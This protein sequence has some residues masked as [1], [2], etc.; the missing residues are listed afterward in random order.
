MG[1]LKANSFDEIWRSPRAEQVRELVKECGRNCWMTGSSV[2]AMR[3]NILKPL[4]WVIGN[5][6]RLTFGRSINEKI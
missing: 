6:F 2:P 3:R 5:K 1:D 4:K